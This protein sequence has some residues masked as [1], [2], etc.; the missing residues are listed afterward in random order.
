VREGTTFLGKK[1]P[2]RGGTIP[3]HSWYRGSTGKERTDVSVQRSDMS[4]GEKR[5]KAS[6]KPEKKRVIGNKKSEQITC[7]GGG[8]EGERDEGPAGGEEEGGGRR[9]PPCRGWGRILDNEANERSRENQADPLRKT[10]G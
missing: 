3:P 8:K 6:R 1:F 2:T 9:E 10:G 4:G 7:G 5:K